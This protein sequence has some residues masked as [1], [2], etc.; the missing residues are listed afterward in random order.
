M[1][2]M[3]KKRINKKHN[4]KPKIRPESLLCIAFA[5]SFCFY[6]VTKIGLN[7]YN[8]TL[9]VEDQKLAS[10]VEEKQQQIDELQ[11]EVNNLEDKTRV[12]GMLGDEV[13]DNQDNVYIID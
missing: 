9:S 8:I 7:S 10:E 3:D 4:R 1:R 12:L 13:K 5:L 2:A 11:S 6:C